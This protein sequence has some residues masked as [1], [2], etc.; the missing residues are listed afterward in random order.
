[1]STLLK[2]L[3]VSNL[4][5]LLV[6]ILRVRVRHHEVIIIFLVNLVKLRWPFVFGVL[7]K[8]FSCLW[9]YIFYYITHLPLYKD[10][11]LIQSH[12]SLMLVSSSQYSKTC[13]HFYDMSAL[14]QSRLYCFSLAFPW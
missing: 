2:L 7:E 11:N 13:R 4:L 6:I 8:A 3:V 14:P 5:K 1:M 10:I 12:L 9:L